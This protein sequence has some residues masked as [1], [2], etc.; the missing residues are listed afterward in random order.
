M[1]RSFLWAL[2]LFLL[3]SCALLQKITEKINWP[4]HIEYIE[5]ICELD[6]AWMDM[7]YS[8]S[9]SLVM[10]Y[11]DRLSIEAYSPFGDTVFFLNRYRNHF[12]L[13]TGEERIT[14]EKGF[15]EK[16][17]LN[18]RDFI[19]DLALKNV[20]HTKS[21]NSEELEIKKDRYRIIYRLKNENTICWEAIEGKICIK[22]I[23][24][25][26]TR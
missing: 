6:M 15:Q 22:F 25:K 2:C 9:M 26:F 17:N 24:A 21:E 8:G 19:D 16:F 14:S 1:R 7:N 3:F 12:L 10:E 20:V 5:A 18:I 11:P 13:L 23:E 4:E